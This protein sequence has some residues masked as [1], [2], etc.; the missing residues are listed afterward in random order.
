MTPPE[1]GGWEEGSLFGPLLPLSRTTCVSR[2]PGRVLWVG[3]VTNGARTQ[4]TLTCQG[5]EGGRWK[6][7]GGGE[8]RQYVIHM[9]AFF[10]LCGRFAQIIAF[11]AFFLLL[12]CLF[13]LLFSFF[14]LF[15]S[16]R[17][18]DP[19]A[20]RLPVGKRMV[21]TLAQA[22]PGGGGWVGWRSDT[23]RDDRFFLRGMLDAQG[24]V[25]RGMCERE[26]ER[27]DKGGGQKKGVG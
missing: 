9:F 14:G 27:R 17:E 23:G 18:R 21:L 13:F 12:F 24:R 3:G 26:N 25:G 6:E 2:L 10:L 7:G 20:V 1:G 5:E 8:R 11:L 22:P 4:C 19:W 15:S 16:G